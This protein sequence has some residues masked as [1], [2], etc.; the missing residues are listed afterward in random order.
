MAAKHS[1]LGLWVNGSYFP[2]AEIERTARRI[3]PLAQ[4]LRRMIPQPGTMVVYDPGARRWRRWLP[5]AWIATTLIVAAVVVLS[6]A[7]VFAPLPADPFE[8]MR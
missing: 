5:V 3:S 8:V 6:G 2:A 1:P 4:T 7:A